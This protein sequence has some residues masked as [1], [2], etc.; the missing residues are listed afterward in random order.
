[1]IEKEQKKTTLIKNRGKS[2]KWLLLFLLLLLLSC[3]KTEY[4]LRIPI[5]TKPYTFDPIMSDEYFSNLVNRNIFDT[6]IKRERNEY[7]SILVDYWTNTSE[8][9]TRIKLKENIRFSDGSKLTADDIKKSLDRASNH[10]LSIYKDVIK[11]DSV[12]ILDR[13]NLH[14]YHNNMDNIIRFLC[15]V[16]IYRANYLENFSEEYLKN[17]PLSTGPYYLYS[18]DIT[19]IVLKKNKLHV[20]YLNKKNIQTPDNVILLIEP[21]LEVQYQMFKSREVDLLLDLPTSVYHQI[22]FKEDFASLVS[23]SNTFLYIMFDNNSQHGHGINKSTNLF[24]DKRVRQAII[25]AIDLN[26]FINITLMGKA[27]KIAIPALPS[28]KHYPHNMNT[29]DYNL[30]NSKLL[31]KEAGLIDGFEMILRVKDNQ[32]TNLL[33]NYIKESLKVIDVIIT[34]EI[35]NKMDFEQSL[36]DR[37]VSAYLS[38]Y[39]ADFFEDIKDAIYNLFYYSTTEKGSLN[40]YNNYDYQINTK[41]DSLLTLN[42]SD[43]RMMGIS[44]RLSS[45]IFNEMVVFPLINTFNYFLFNKENDFTYIDDL[46]FL[47]FRFGK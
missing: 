1:L 24:K 6:L 11:L 46:Y 9:F 4:T 39:Q 34:I 25:Q 42:E 2:K 10:P 23:V 40:T 18:N 13:Y 47:N 31:L 22:T 26:T 19:Q 15:K 20:D 32:F 17:K 27:N 21:S 16:P 38:L 30:N 35:E 29:Y 43:R 28:N 12:V 37:P 8:N 7:V 36:I 45:T 41:L 5:Q 33:A 44:R 14:I 3:K